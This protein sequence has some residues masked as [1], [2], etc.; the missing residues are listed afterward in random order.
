MIPKET[1]ETILETARIDEVVGDYVS[2]K[3]R[4][5]NYIGLCPFHNEK[6]PSF[7]V[8][9]AKGIYKCFGCGAAGNA[10]NFVMEH[11]HISYPEALRYLAKKYNITIEEENVTPEQIEQ[12][13]ERESLFSV[14]QFAQ[15]HFTENL[16]EKEEGKA[17][18]LTYFKERGFNT[19]TIS[20]FQLGYAVDSYEDLF[21]AAKKAGYKMELLEKT[22]LLKSREDRHFDFFRARVIFP[23]HNITGKVIGF[24]ARTLKT[25][26]KEPK[27]LNSPETEVYNKS[28][29]LYGMFFAKRAI[30]ANDNCFLVEGYTDVISLAQAGIENVVASSGTSLT[31][32]QIRLIKRYTP[33]IT[34]LYD[35]DAAGIKASFRGIDMILSEGMNVKVLLFPEGED[36]DSYSKKVSTQE[37][38]QFI[39]EHSKDFILFKTDVLLQEAQSDPVK[40]AGLIK[41]LLTS[42]ALVPDTITRSVYVK[43]CSKMFEMT[44]QTLLNEL[45]KIRRNNSAKEKGVDIPLPDMPAEIP[46]ETIERAQE[47]EL[48][49]QERDLSR[50]LLNYGERELEF[51]ITVEDE[52]VG[53]DGKKK[54]HQEILQT[55]VAEFII[56]Q[57]ENDGLQFDHQELQSI[58]SEYSSSIKLGVVPTQNHFINQASA[59]KSVYDLIMES[60]VVSPK[61]KSKHNVFITAEDEKLSYMVRNAVY[62]YKL[63]KVMQMIY[64]IE[65]EL[66]T[67]KEEENINTLLQYM[68]ALL[69]VKKKLSAELGR[70]IIK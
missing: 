50:I 32:G 28:N 48:L 38:H 70:V 40:K 65:E 56:H 13:S 35:G 63:K 15:K 57:L 20:K 24:G 7:T 60:Y 54:I 59:S 27:Y 16:T 26:K 17:I 2:L 52:E 46:S 23:I 25:D 31:T 12:Q 6:T 51:E 64:S 42:V 39:A 55:T 41:E 29:I 4:G 45:N 53:A 47:D 9:P 5:A 66:K 61:W 21:Q 58:F 14:L 30:I 22:G 11:D 62:S 18:G 19:A 44:E 1:I 36:P 33:N 67:E 8:S 43:E 34:I 69:E 68:M 49:Y 10:V 3:K 37:L